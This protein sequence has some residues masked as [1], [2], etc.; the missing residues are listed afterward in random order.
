MEKK[1]VEKREGGYWISG[2]RISLDSMV[3]AF[4]RGDSPETI[5]DNFTSLTLEEVYGALAF[6][7]GNQDKIDIYL[8]ESEVLFEKESEIRR[9]ELQRDKPE[10]MERL[11]NTRVLT[12]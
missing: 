10:L 5:K 1:Y 8:R 3:Y 2:T 7:L 12:R 6:Y 4:N 11:R 9:A